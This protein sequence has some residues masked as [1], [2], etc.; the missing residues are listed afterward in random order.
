MCENDK[1]EE[2]TTAEAAGGESRDDAGKGEVEEAAASVPLL[3][4]VG[5]A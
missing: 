4:Y 1:E 3:A 2:P 5:G